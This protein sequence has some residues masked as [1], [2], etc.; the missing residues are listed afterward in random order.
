MLG[1]FS[2]LEGV[3]IILRLGFVPED[4]ELYELTPDQYRSYYATTQEH[5]GESDESVYMILPKDSQKYMELASED[6]FVITESDIALM[7]LGEKLI[8]SYCEKSEKEFN[9]F[10]EKLRYC[11]SVMPSVVSKGTKYEKYKTRFA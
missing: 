7:K 5:R 9:S 8:E 6:V 10:E 1:L 4:N 2:D 11:A 3:M